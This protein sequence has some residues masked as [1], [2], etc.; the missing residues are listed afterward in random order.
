MMR[1]MAAVGAFLLLFAGAARATMIVPFDLGGLV[2]QASDVVVARVEARAS[3]WSSD[4]RAIY[5][6]VTLRV[7]HALKGTS[8]EGDAVT[9]RT[10]GGSVDGIG[11]RVQGAAYF[12]VGEE[13]VA[14]LERRGAALWTV[15]M[16][17]GKMRVMAT[18]SRRVAVRDVGG[19]SFTERTPRPA[20]EPN[21]RPL[22]ELLAAI[23]DRVARSRP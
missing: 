21:V 3:R 6:E 9:V 14:F 18:N 2:D 23:A 7:E 4:K 15:G 11:M 8:R 13:V 22:D 10:E 5:T 19:L 17:Q 1:R 20:P 12:T 16:A